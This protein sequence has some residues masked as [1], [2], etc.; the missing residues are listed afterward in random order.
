MGA[1]GTIEMTE[2]ADASPVQLSGL[3]PQI[4][5]LGLAIGLL[6]NG[7]SAGTYTLNTQW[8]QNPLAQ[9][10][11][12]LTANGAG[13]ASLLEAVL[14][15][16]GGTAL[17][18][19]AEDP[20]TL[21]TWYPVLNPSTGQPT[22]LYIVA[23]T[24][25]ASTVF[26]VGVNHAW[27]L[28]QSLSVRAWAL[29]PLIS[30]GGNSVES[31]YSGSSPSA[32]TVGIETVSSTPMV[33]AYGLQL[34]GMRLSGS[35]VPGGNA[36]IS[37]VATG[38]QLPGQA[39]PSDQSLADLEQLTGAQILSTVSTVF[40][41]AMSE[42]LS[43]NTANPTLGYV[44]PVL[45]LSPVLPAPVTALFP[46]VQ[47]PVL[48]W[49]EII[50]QASGGDLAKPFKDWF[51]TLLSDSQTM[52]AWLCSIQGLEG[53]T[54]AA[55]TGDGSRAN[56]WS[57][58]ILNAASV[59]ALS[60]TFATQT[61]SA[62]VRTFFPGLT[63]A[64]KKYDLG[65]GAALRVSAD[66]ELAQF[67]LAPGN[68]SVSI[69]DLEF[70][71]GIEL[72]GLG[73]T[74]GVDNPVFSG[75]ISGATYTFGS[76]SAGLRISNTSG[77]LSVV[78]S[79][80]L[81]NLVTP[82]G[83]F[84]S[85]DLL[86][87]GQVVNAAETVLM[88]LVNAALQTLFGI[89]ANG[90][91][92]P[93]YALAAMLGIVSPG[94]A[95]AGAWP[96]NPPLSATELINSLQNPVAALGNYYYQVVA[97]TAKLGNQAP[98]YY[99]L[100]E[101]ATL[102][103]MAS[104]GAPAV[105]GT[106][107]A[108][109]PWQ[110]RIASS[111][112]LTANLEAYVAAQPDG[113]QLLVLGFGL[114]LPLALTAGLTVD[115]AMDI[116]LLGL[117]LTATSVR[118]QMLP[119]L[120]LSVTLPNGYTSPAVGGT[121]VQVGASGIEMGWSPYTG[122]NWSAQ[123]GQPVLTA[124]G[125]R[126]PVGQDMVFNQ[127]A[128]LEQLVTQQAQ[129]F[130]QVLTGVLGLAVIRA[131]KTAGL[132]FAGLLGLLPDLGPLMPPGLT[133]PAGM[134]VLSVT[135]FNDPLGAL[136]KQIAGLAGSAGNLKAA[137]GL[138]A[139]ASSGTVQTIPGSGTLDDPFFVP[140][141][142]A[143]GIGLAVWTDA[144]SGTVGFGLDRS[145]TASVTTSI[146][147]TTR[148]TLRLLN[149]SL[150]TGAQATAPDVPG[151]R[152]LCTLSNPAGQ[153]LPPT[154]DG[155]SLNSI[156]VGLDLSVAGTLQS[157]TLTVTPEFNLY[158]LV[159]QNQPA[160]PVVSLAAPGALTVGLV[161]QAFNAALSVVLP[162]A[163]KT[164]PFGQ[165][166]DLLAVTG[167]AVSQSSG[168]P[169]GINPSGWN[170]LLADPVSFAGE[171]LL[172]LAT[173]PANQATL[174][175]VLKKAT[176]ITLPQIPASVLELLSALGIL[177]GESAGYVP[178]PAAIVQ[179]FSHPAQYLQAQFSSLIKDTAALTALLADLQQ[180]TGI[181]GFGPFALQILSGPVVSLSIPAGKVNAGG[182]LQV[183]GALNLALSSGAESLTL[184]MA[185]Y[186]PQVKLALEPALTVN[187]SGQANFAASLTWGDGTVP[188]PSPLQ[189][190]PFNATVFVPALAQVA[191][192]YALSVLVSEAVD[193]L[194][195]QP[196]PLVQ[197]LFEIFG[198][199]SKDSSG[200]WHTKS[201]LG[202]FQDPVNW[203]LSDAVLG[204][205]GQL[206]IGQLNKLLANVPAVANANGLALAQVTNGITLTGLP[207]GLAVTLTA[208][209][210]TN[211]VALTPALARP[212]PLGGSGVTL[213]ALSAGLTL[214][215]DFQPGFTGAI[216]VGLTSPA[217]SLQAGYSGGFTLAVIA[218][219]SNPAT[220][221]LVPFAGWQALVQSA[222]PLVIQT[223]VQELTSKLLSALNSAGAT[224]F[225]TALQT[226]GTN[227]QV[228][229][230]VSALVAAGADATA[231]EA[232]AL[233]WLGQRVAVANAPGT[234]TAIAA[235]LSPVVSN[236]ASQ[237]GLITFTGPA[238]LPVTLMLG[239]NAQSQVGVWASIKLPPIPGIQL[240]IQTTGIGLPVSASGSI[241]TTPQIAFGVEIGV[242]IQ[243]EAQYPTLSLA[244][245]NQ[246]YFIASL[247]P[248]GAGASP[249][250]LSVELLPQFFGAPPNLTSAVEQWLLNVLEQAVP[251]YLSLVVLNQSD[252]KGWLTTSLLGTTPANALVAAGLLVN[253]S[254]TFVLPTY[255]ALG[256]LT[257]SSVLTGLAKSL[258]GA[259]FTVLTFND[260]Q[261]QIIVGPSSPGAGDCG[262][263]V[264]AQNVS[265]PGTSQF[266]IQIGAS[267]TGW[268]KEAGG[269]SNLAAGFGIFVPVNPALNFAAL[270]VQLVN[271]GVDFTGKQNTPLVQMSRFSLGA[272]QPRAV[273]A[274][275]FSKGT[276]PVAWG[277]AM[278]LEDVALSLAPQSLSAG[279]TNPVAQNL[280]GS[281]NSNGGG[282]TA[283]Q[284]ANPP[285]SIRA[286]YMSGGNL[287]LELL[288]DGQEAKEVWIPVQQSFGPLH[289]NMIGVEL[290]TGSGQTRAGVG[291]DG[292]VALA[293]LTVDVEKLT[294]SLNLQA[295]TDYSQYQLDLA[296]LDVSFQ[297]G[298]VQLSGAFYK[299]TNPL[300]YTGA[301]L[302]K[303]ANFSLNA[304]GSYAVVP[305]NASLPS[306]QQNPNG[307]NCPQAAS[308]FVF[309]NLNAILGGPPAFV[310]VG[311]AA[312]F[313][314]NRNIVIPPVSEISTFPFV[315][316]ATKSDY[317]GPAEKSDPSKALTQISS[318]VPPMI[319]AYWVAAG[320]KFTSFQLL[321]SFA[322][323][324]VKFGQNFEIDLVG[325]SSAALPPGS[326]Q[327]LVYV[328]LGL[329]V[330][331]R[332]ADGV[333][334]VQAQLTPNSYLL[335]PSCQLTGGFALV[336]W[337]SGDFVVTLG[338]YHPAYQVPSNYPIVPRLGFNW[339]VSVSVGS[340]SIAGGAYFALTPTAI[341]AGGYLQVAF[342]LGPIRAWLNAGADFLIQWKPFYYDI[343]VQVSIGVAFHTTI[344][345]VSITIS[346][347]L[348]AALHL[349][350]PSTAGYAE[351]DWY[352]ISFTIPIGDQ[353]KNTNT[354]YL[355]TWGDFATNFLPPASNS[356]QSAAPGGDTAAAPPPG[357]VLKLSVVDGL[358]AG[359]PGQNAGSGTAN[360]WVM[361]SSGW[362]LRVDTAVPATAMQVNAVSFNDGQPIGVRPMNVPGVTT[363]LVATLQGWNVATG[364][365]QQIDLAA[366]SIAT[367]AVTA[368]APNALWSQSPMNLEAPPTGSTVILGVYVGLT[369]A[370]ND[371]TL[372]DPIG[373]IPL[374]TAFEFQPA[375]VIIVPP[376]P[377]WAAPAAYAQTNPLAR[378]MATIMA[379]EVVKMRDEVLAAVRA[380]GFP[381]LDH[382]RLPVLA[383]YADALYQAPPVLAAV[384]TGITAAPQMSFTQA[385]PQAKAIAAT[386]EAPPSV[387]LIG[388]AN[389]YLSGE[390][391]AV[392]TAG[393]TA[394][395]RLSSARVSGR[396][397]ER[398][399]TGVASPHLDAFRAI[400]RVAG[401]GALEPA[402]SESVRLL[403]GS[404]A[405]LGLHIPQG[406]T[407]RLDVQGGLPV[408]LIELNEHDEVIGDRIV[409][410]G[411]RAI[412][413]GETT[414]TALC[415][416]G[417][418]SAGSRVVGWQRDTSLTQVGRYSFVGDG[419]TV[420]PQVPPLWREN[421]RYVKHGLMEVAH[422]L[423]GN[424]VQVRGESVPGWLETV[425]AGPVG[426]VAIAVRAE[427]VE[428]ARSLQ[429]RLAWSAQAWSPVYDAA[430]EAATVVD[431]E[432]GAI[433][434][435]N[436]P[437]APAGAKWLGVLV[438]GPL[439]PS[440]EGVWGL[441]DEV[442][443]LHAQWSSLRAPAAG[444]ALEDEEPAWSNAVVAVDT[445]ADEPAL[446]ASAG[447]ERTRS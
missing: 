165:I 67:V 196:Y 335:A 255:Q 178:I 142:L 99:M 361:N 15:S 208:N 223:L 18:I 290:E 160:G 439:T 79:F 265:L 284:A 308:L 349:W 120:E 318:V 68:T 78:P 389:R 269:P 65:G 77:S 211:Q 419:F 169:L 232:A 360:A 253:N 258:L 414:H 270:K 233:T 407:G 286:G 346:A 37:L 112:S 254:G 117:G 170:A 376:A 127:A 244:Y 206:Q 149:V 122:W 267:D 260:G 107:T 93:A 280:L 242:P 40:V 426:S 268:I 445:P 327:T 444:I 239:L 300:Q 298:A 436:A 172:A 6:Q 103:N 275:D 431:A 140:M 331:F 197:A 312:G 81:T 324:F 139:W 362:Q 83:T 394:S 355:G 159:L 36:S 157:P 395:L 305:V 156:S 262:V 377:N 100:R 277:G 129:T 113:S 179:L 283:G 225:V 443:Q 316:G 384:G 205:N 176:G 181:T 441:A 128:S 33:N 234:A 259:T 119:G 22:G 105:T 250:P 385:A 52:L 317:F 310:V 408:R 292:S 166:Y 137:L 61:N 193:P 311:L 84:A 304:M 406:H 271:V 145:S 108:A 203:L 64:G 222:A 114:G 236:V 74:G 136:W 296:G 314:Y 45:G 383:A 313:G 75:T 27:P 231:L 432:G 281:G 152:L 53:L 401:A 85:L 438:S 328:E 396:W 299:E 440:L 21:G 3:E 404:S 366:Y 174:F 202:L 194:L 285:F 386:V 434:H 237:G 35:L 191:P 217:L 34:G 429:V 357:A 374:E 167:L 144:T 421:G 356:S 418:S 138:L 31:A 363:P 95:G 66:L 13:L 323:L 210:A 9:T 48:R 28:T 80:T 411:T 199:A 409:A 248:M 23:Q 388:A 325:V 373:P 186:N 287:L 397:I 353:N 399:R 96:I 124:A 162:D 339:P 420:R 41:A 158:N 163:V 416:M 212:L 141:G 44:L 90:E 345:G 367:A 104:G 148:V 351:V 412:L 264:V 73:Q 154:P 279:S 282:G 243:G 442:S 333:I 358:A 276:A 352:V 132:A 433:L 245:N 94:T 336:I 263:I 118:A 221:Q 378:L 71:L 368:N 38:L 220:L 342:T 350:G 274:F 430:A 4:A 91:G 123:V 227:L 2:L 405:L 183:S 229:A 379:P 86:Q 424:T 155:T 168:Q 192:F 185:L 101:A 402:A 344:L 102:L 151:A 25:G 161:Q 230:L 30:V 315:Q 116:D 380:Q 62:G 51:N 326:P 437:Q 98:F 241:G 251:R 410:A 110:A 20:D 321:T 369:I 293:G 330:S 72:V 425:L 214:S 417:A 182:L 46:G 273:L 302:L 11:A 252:V 343:S 69:N 249:S 372:D 92:S 131:D 42:A 322:L 14:G 49:D 177:Q 278:T 87:P 235:L 188:A 97:S 446:F 224:S 55:G 82:Q 54:V 381:A 59:G 135:S 106:G 370:G 423:R 200:N 415:G 70:D 294:V 146:Q 56:P 288:Q 24:S 215:S 207:Y 301:A 247:D 428:Q 435:F 289:V 427:N 198:I 39:K 187:F 307:P 364:T 12:A 26:G 126:F 121:S 216:E 218:G 371:L 256:A 190:W 57:I 295:P 173:D 189:V 413:A 180:T 17:G 58:E 365:W 309:V 111:G 204:Q 447:H 32:L 354:N 164:Q 5:Q 306:C 76:L 63:F 403:E 392:Q 47:M 261:G 50:D 10:K 303:F 347:S 109:S 337:F 422:V 8:F 89:S 375:K 338:G 134:P 133:W 1:T 19:P 175:A 240:A 7:S 332:P 147:A 391:G 297:N 238:S 226:A 359:A 184:E 43:G 291:F 348:G 88:G 272:V 201:L 209:T 382:P 341:M 150:A 60:F 257:V 319:G 340:L 115:L 228:S 29:A 143:S 320:V 387:R 390:S 130:G 153:L 219:G 195:L 125:N 16:L 171:R 393:R 266:S 246:G 400:R 398:T 329:L 334:S 213:Q